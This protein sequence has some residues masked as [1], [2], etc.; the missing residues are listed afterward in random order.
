MVYDEEWDPA[1]YDGGATGTK[2]HGEAWERLNNTLFEEWRRF[3]VRLEEYAELREQDRKPPLTQAQRAEHVSRFRQR[4][5]EKYGA[6]AV[7]PRWEGE[8]AK[9]QDARNQPAPYRKGGYAA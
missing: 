6:S 8:R 4:L 9:R 2:G 1:G 3:N 7:D 5:L